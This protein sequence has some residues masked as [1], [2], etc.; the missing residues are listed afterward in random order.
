VKRPRWKLRTAMAVTALIALIL[1][2]AI[3]L[4]RASAY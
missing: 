2:P 1:A 4:I 3:G